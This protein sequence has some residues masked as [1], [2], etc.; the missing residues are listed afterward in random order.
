MGEEKPSNDEVDAYSRKRYPE[1][2]TE[3]GFVHFTVR[4]V[5]TALEYFNLTQGQ[6]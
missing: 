3:V 5:E 6:K 4:P 2:Y 1:E